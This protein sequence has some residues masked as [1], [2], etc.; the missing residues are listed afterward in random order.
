MPV[1]QS[2]R[3]PARQAVLIGLGVLC[4]LGALVFLVTR[5]DSLT[6]GGNDSVGLGQPVFVVGAASEFALLVDANGPLF[7]PD[8]AQGDRDI[9][10]HHLGEEPSEGWVAFA[11]R[12][13]TAPRECTVEWNGED[14]TFVDA[15]DG[16]V[17]PADGEGLQQ[18]AV[19]VD[20]QGDVTVNL[21]Q[22]RP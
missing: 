15:C 19:S 9:W 21:N 16:T 5:F 3:S 1:A 22:T 8:G 10:L 7:L 12:P 4:G 13:E 20:L 17:Y 14:E 2:S 18:F 6:A 11:V